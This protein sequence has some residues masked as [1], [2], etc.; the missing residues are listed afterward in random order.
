MKKEKIIIIETTYPNLAEAK[1][2]AKI[3]LNQKLA[4]CIHFQKIETMYVWQEKIEDGEEILLRIKCIKSNF[5]AIEKIIKKHH[6]YMVPEIISI[7][8][9]EA[10]E[11]YATWL[12]NI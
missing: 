5:S 2:L 8:V 11:K 1:N 7:V 6:S 12:Q 10:E 9:D 3:L 4:G